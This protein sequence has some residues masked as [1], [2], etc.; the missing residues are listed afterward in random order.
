MEI[1]QAAQIVG[2]VGGLIAALR[3][4]ID[5]RNNIRLQK[6][7]IFQDLHKSIYENERFEPIIKLIERSI[8]NKKVPCDID[9]ALLNQFLVHLERVELAIRGNIISEELAHYYFGY[10][11]TRLWTWPEF[12]KK[13]NVRLPVWAIFA[14]F[15]ERMSKI[16]VDANPSIYKRIKL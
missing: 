2:I 15:V 7:D 9:P 3:L 10:Y 11:A 6:Y 12:H 8:H 4:L 1:S 14:S 13:K 16:D 5:Y